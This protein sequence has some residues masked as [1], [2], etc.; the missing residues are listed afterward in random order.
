MRLEDPVLTG[1]LETLEIEVLSSDNY[2]QVLEGVVLE[3]DYMII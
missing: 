2:H 3:M 1:M